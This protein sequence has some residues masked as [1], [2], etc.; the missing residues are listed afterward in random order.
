MLECFTV[1]FYLHPLHEFFYSLTGL[2]FGF[3]VSHCH[4][5]SDHLLLSDDEDIVR[6]FHLSISDLLSEGVRGVIELGS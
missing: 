4:C 6:V 1:Y 5:T 3:E 2:G